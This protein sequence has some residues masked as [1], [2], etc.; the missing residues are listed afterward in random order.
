[1]FIVYQSF[2]VSLFQPKIE[3]NVKIMRDP[4]NVH[5]R[6]A[7]NANYGISLP[8]INQRKAQVSNGLLRWFATQKKLSSLLLVVYGKMQIK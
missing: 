7:V 4:E 6:A 8:Y 2:I 5:H 1:M 3:M